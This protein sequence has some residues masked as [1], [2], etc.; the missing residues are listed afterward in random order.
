MIKWMV[1][2]KMEHSTMCLYAVQQQQLALYIKTFH[3]ERF[4]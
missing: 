1:P 4:L 3:Q 2:L